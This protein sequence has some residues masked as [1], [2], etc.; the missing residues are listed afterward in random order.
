MIECE[1]NE[2]MHVNKKEIRD[3][4]LK[5]KKKKKKKTKKK[6]KERRK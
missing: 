2:R 4:N 3:I 5:K 1:M 6:T